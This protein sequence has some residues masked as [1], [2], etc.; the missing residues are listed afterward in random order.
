VK[1]RFFRH[2]LDGNDADAVRV[3][4][5][6]IEKRSGSRMAAGL[7]TDQWKCTLDDYVA[8]ASS[9]CRLMAHHGF[10]TVGAVPVDPDGELLDGSHR[11]A[12]ALALGIEAVPMTHE[13][14]K[15]WAPAWGLQL[16]IDNG[17]D[18]A[19]LSRLKADWEAL[20]DV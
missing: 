17:M 10:A 1:W 8:S 15:V 6:H 12:C 11:V 19:G 2:L 4:L 9:L 5:W 16:F 7:A 18:E 20:K 3:Y 14:R 13:T